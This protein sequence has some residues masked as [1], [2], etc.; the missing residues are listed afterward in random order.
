MI[1]LIPI[2]GAR[3]C[4]GA[5]LV[6]TDHYSLKFLLDQRLSTVP[7]HQW[8]SNLFGYDFEVEY[9]SERLNVA[10]DALSHLYYADDDAPR[11]TSAVLVI[12]R[13]SFAF[14]E[15]VRRATTAATD[16][17]Q[18]LGRLRTVTWACHGTRTQN[19]YYTTDASTCQTP[20][21]CATKR[22]S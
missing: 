2:T 11:A 15:D 20:G 10:L 6:R 9:R 13:T 19:F 17:Q 18:L 1:S 8:I 14:L 7:Q 3:I 21:T 12:S 5:F 22:S 16:A 4:G